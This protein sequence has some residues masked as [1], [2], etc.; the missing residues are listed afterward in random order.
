[1]TINKNPNAEPERAAFGRLASVFRQGIK[2]LGWVTAAGLLALVASTSCET[3]VCG[4]FKIEGD[5]TCDDGNNIDG[6]GC[7]AF[8]IR[9]IP[10]GCGNGV[11]GAGEECDDGNNL[12]GDGCSP[13]C[14]I[15]PS[16]SIDF[17]CRDMARPE[18]ICKLGEC[19]IG[20]RTDQDCQDERICDNGLTGIG[21]IAFCDPAMGLVCK[22]SLDP[23]VCKFDFSVVEGLCVTGCRPFLSDTRCVPGKVCV[24]NGDGTGICVPAA[25]CTTDQSCNPINFDTFP[26]G[27]VVADGTE[28][29]NQYRSEGAEFSSTSGGPCA[30]AGPVSEASS[31]PLFIIGN[32]NADCTTFNSFDPIN[33]DIVD[34]LGNPTTTDR[35]CVTLISV[36]E[37]TVTAR[38]TNSS[39]VEVDSKVVTNPGTGSGDGNQD[40]IVLSGAGIQKVTIAITIPFG[41]DGIGIDD[42][43]VGPASCPC[44]ATST[45][46]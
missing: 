45:C 22:D 42:V 37:A 39:S 40:P 30:V 28:I 11:L 9:E 25:D 4:D 6:D 3:I 32:N 16:C 33:I 10:P 31:D 27:G 18:G 34:A 21:C 5:E 24:D 19:E 23:P 13:F 12:G 43:H 7:S 14:R 36:G 44:E 2:S 26:G 46:S 29:T 20:C 15:E 38:A 35:V 8:C 17:E 1:M 41:G